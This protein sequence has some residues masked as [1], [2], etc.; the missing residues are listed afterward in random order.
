MSEERCRCAP[1]TSG[2]AH[3][4]TLLAAAA[5][6]IGTAAPTRPGDLLAAFDWQRVRNADR[7]MHWTGRSLVDST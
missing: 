4:G 1:T 7:L 5:G 3:P 6:L 2:P